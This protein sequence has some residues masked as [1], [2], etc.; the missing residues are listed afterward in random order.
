MSRPQT[1][2]AANTARSMA[3]KYKKGAGLVALA[4]EFDLSV[5]VIRRTLVNGG[6]KI[7]GRGAPVGPRNTAD[8]TTTTTRA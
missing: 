1:T 6:A 8:K 2:V 3:A 5:P 4:E 7:R